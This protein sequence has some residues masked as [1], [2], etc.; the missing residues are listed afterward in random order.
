MAMRLWM[1]GGAKSDRF[2]RVLGSVIGLASVWVGALGQLSTPGGRAYF[3]VNRP[4]PILV[5]VPKPAGAAAGT[6][7]PA[8]DPAAPDAPITPIAGEVRID[9]FEVGRDGAV[10]TAPVLADVPVDLAGLFPVLWQGPMPK[11]RY[12]QLVVG[13]QE[14]GAPLVLQPMMS[15]P[16]AKLVDPKSRR[17]WFRDPTTNED[18]FRPR[19][20]VM[21]W[22]TEPPA[23][24]GLRIYADQH[25]ILETSLGEM[26]FRL[27][28][29]AA[30]N[31]AWNFRELV[32]QGFYTDIIFHR[33][34]PTL[35]SGH[36]FV[37]QM[38]DPTGT[39][40]GGPGYSIDLERSTLMHDFGVLSMARSD[41]PDTNGSQIFI[42]LSREGTARLDGLYTAF[43]EMVRGTETLVA[44][45]KVPVKDQRP[46]DP[47]ILQSARLVD[48]PAWSARPARV[49][50]PV[51]RPSR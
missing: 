3:G 12:A 33:I 10:A 39:G 6:D 32:R 36:P 5:T 1:P 48:A 43:G 16:R 40:D 9:L 30:P 38:G 8:Q 34:V 23:Y 28:P 47:P 44:L 35:A 29:D 24:A 41:D 14:V 20:G 2:A 37:V 25:V 17:V 18:N 50:R 31:S 22:V 49:Q 4:I 45:S 27:R 21:E 11:L 7:T 42:A 26:E 19:E 13:G 51:E 46:A 15:E